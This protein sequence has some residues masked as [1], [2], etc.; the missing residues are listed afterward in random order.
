[1]NFIVL[2]GFVNQKKDVSGRLLNRERQQQTQ[3]LSN[4]LYCSKDSFYSDRKCLTWVD[5]VWDSCLAHL[6]L[7]LQVSPPSPSPPLFQV[8][9]LL[10]P[11]ENFKTVLN[12]NQGAKNIRDCAE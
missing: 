12:G 7:F 9:S 2:K 6:C 4:V 1:M 5:P 10:S 11:V 3:M 8:S